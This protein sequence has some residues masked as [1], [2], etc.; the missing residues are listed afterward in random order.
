VQRARGV[1]VAI[2]GWEHHNGR[3]HARYISCVAGQA[4]PLWRDPAACY[5]W[6]MPSILIAAILGSIVA[7]GAL[8]W[9]LLKLDRD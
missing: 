9:V 2:G 7:T 5:S 6:A 3:F 4:K 1:A 8:T